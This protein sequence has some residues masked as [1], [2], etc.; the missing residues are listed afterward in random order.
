MRNRC[1]RVMVS[2]DERETGA[3][4]RWQ[5]QRVIWRDHQG[6]LG[7][8]GSRSAR[9]WSGAGPQPTSG[10]DLFS[11]PQTR[12]AN[13]ETPLEATKVKV[14]IMYITFVTLFFFLVHLS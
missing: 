13:P 1:V 5:G 12:P 2:G 6:A 9:N 11:P 7:I 3:Q 4:G 10:R 8:L 14:P